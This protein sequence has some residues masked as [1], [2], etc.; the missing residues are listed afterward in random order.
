VDTSAPSGQPLF[1]R[2]FAYNSTG[3]SSLSGE[4]STAVT[5]SVQDDAVSAGSNQLTFA[6]LANGNGFAFATSRVARATISV[7]DV[8]GRFLATPFSEV[9]AGGEHH[10]AWSRKSQMGHA[11]ASGVYFA[12]L[13]LE[14]GRWANQKFVIIR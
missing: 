3:V 7:Y 10:V 14:D 6:V 11:L 12:R 2:V 13:Q 9:V 4:A 8:Q 1:Y 5:T